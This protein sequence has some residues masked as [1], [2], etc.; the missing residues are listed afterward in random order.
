LS[1][2]EKSKAHPFVGILNPDEVLLWWHI[3]QPLTWREKWSLVQNSWLGWLLAVQILLDR[4]LSAFQLKPKLLIAYG[5]TNR[6][7]LKRTNNK[8]VGKPLNKFQVP[9]KIIY[10]GTRAMLNLGRTSWWWINIETH[11]AEY[12]LQL[13]E[14]AKVRFKSLS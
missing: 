8:I 12:A 11:E 13:I 7:L 10:Q 14:Q 9:T 5:V 2:K 6:R 1:D 3:P 4:V